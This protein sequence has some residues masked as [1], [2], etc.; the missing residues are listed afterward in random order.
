MD[1]TQEHQY[2][3]SY[4]TEQNSSGFVKFILGLFTGAGIAAPITALIVKKICDRQKNDAVIE[5]ENRGMQAMVDVCREEVAKGATSANLGHF[6]ASRGI[7][8][9]VSVAG[10]NVTQNDVSEGGKTHGGT[11]YDEAYLASLQSPSDD[12]GVDYDLE[13]YNLTIDDEEATQEA[14]EFSESHV[15]YLNMIERYKNRGGDIP[16]M[17]IDRDQFA[18]EHYYEKCY[19]NWYEDDDVFEEEDARI[20]DPGYMFGFISGRDMFSPDR[21][22]LREDPN[23]CYIRN[24]KLSTD[25]EITRMHGSYQQMVVDGEAYYHG[26]ADPKH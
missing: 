13:N 17:T 15:Q 19:V 10:N 7:P 8:E 2:T 1:I 11:R 21:T 5:A 9:G 16:P 23:I 24:M 25:F 12:D 26:E 6:E 4:S 18:N 20:E 22:A 14:R 3:S